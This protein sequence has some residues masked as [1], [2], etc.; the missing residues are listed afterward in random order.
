MQIII[1]ARALTA[2]VLSIAGVLAKMVRGCQKPVLLLVLLFLYAVFECPAG[3][4]VLRVLDLKDLKP[5]ITASCCPLSD[6]GQPCI[7]DQC[8][9]ADTQP[10]NIAD[11]DALTEWV[12]NFLSQR[13]N[14]ASPQAAFSFNFGQV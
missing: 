10:G 9:V 1:P 12:V 3:E 4:R 5:Q 14:G 13:S 2:T 7:E 8:P 6:A 11:G